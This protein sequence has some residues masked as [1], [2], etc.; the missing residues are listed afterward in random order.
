MSSNCPLGWL[1]GLGLPKLGGE[2]RAGWQLGPGLSNVGV[3]RR[4]VLFFT[5]EEEKEPPNGRRY[6]VYDVGPFPLWI[7]SV[8]LGYVDPCGF[9]VGVCVWDM[10]VCEKG[11]AGL[12]VSAYVYMR[13]EFLCVRE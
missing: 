13:G 10:Y 9:V 8:F 7:P 5:P 2:R 11:V 3:G 12:W 1:S 6:G 4:A